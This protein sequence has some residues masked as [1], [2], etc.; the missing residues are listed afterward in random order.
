MQLEKRSMAGSDVW[1]TRVAQ[2]V[3]SVWRVDNGVK[4][5]FQAN[6][7]VF[8]AVTLIADAMASVPW[9]VFDNDNTALWD[10][11]ISKLLRTPNPK[12]SRNQMMHVIA[13]WLQL[14][15]NAYLKMV[16]DSSKAPVELWPVSPD[17]LAPKPSA[18]PARFIDG[19]EELDRNGVMRMS[20]DYTPENTIHIKLTNPANP[21]VGISPLG[22]AAKAIDL[23]NA[24]MGWNKSGMQ[25]RGVFDGMFSFKQPVDAPMAKSLSDRIKEKFLGVRNARKPLVLGSD[26][27]YQRM[28][29]TPAEV[30]FLASRKFNRE[31]IF[32]VFGVP[33]QLG[34]SQE[35]STY[36]NFA[37]ATRVFW[38][39][40]ILPDIDRVR[41]S[42]QAMLQPWLSEGLTIGPDLS[43]IRALQENED[44]RAKVAELYTKMGVPFSQINERYELGFKPWPGWDRP[45]SVTAAGGIKLDEEPKEDSKRWAIKP[46]E[47][48]S[49]QDEAAARDRYA[50]G[51]M[52]RAIADLLEIQQRDVFE[53]LEAG[54]S[55]QDAV[56]LR[57]DEWV[58]LLNKSIMDVA[59]SAGAAILDGVRGKSPTLEKRDSYSPEMVDAITQALEAESVTL[60]ELSHIHESTVRTI[61]D[62]VTYGVQNEMTIA[63]IQQAL[64]DTGVFSAERALRISRTVAGTAMSVGQMAAG[65]MAG[66]ETK[67]WNASGLE[68]REEHSARDGEE[69]GIDERF[70]V[71]FGSVGPRYPC[72]PEVDASDRVNC[73]CWLTFG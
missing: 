27:Q 37:T 40:K 4:E 19:Y 42:L 62:Q 14:S 29:L 6:A 43:N 71:Q 66:A 20:R 32:I 50:E 59:L 48:R 33:P 39:T 12:W 63:G 46:A 53:A 36:N 68:T 24:Q 52:K 60:N 49:P 16:T 38:E 47:Q 18:D 73:R 2:A 17:R 21:Y 13:C 35:A 7:W 61:I 10:H 15:G 55:P 58:A 31:E 72:D 3:W 57:R 25:N 70:S 5:G 44:E 9:V 11:P 51:T 54:N 56:A 23:D 65:K 69:V 22:A 67:T 45:R 28:S 41:D 30:D 8:R 1:L 26:A 34:G 64:L